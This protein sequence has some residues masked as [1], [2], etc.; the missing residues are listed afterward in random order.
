[1]LKRLLIVILTLITFVHCDLSAQCTPVIGTNPS[2]PKGCELFTVQ[3]FDS[4]DCIIQQRIWSFGDGQ[5]STVE[6]PIHS[7][8]ASVA[9]TD[10]LFNV[11]LAVQDIGGIWTSTSIPVTVYNKP[12][13]SF[14]TDLDTAC[15]INDL[16][17]MVNSSSSGSEFTYN[18]DYGDLTAPGNAFSANHIY[19]NPGDYTITLTVTDTN[20]CAQI[21]QQV[22]TVNEI[23]NPNFSLSDIVGCH[24][25]T[26]EISNTTVPGTFPITYWNWDYSGLSSESTEASSGFTFNDPGIYAITLSA[27]NSA[28]CSNSTANNVFVNETPTA[29]F[30]LPDEACK[31]D[32]VIAV[33]GGTGTFVGSY[34]WSGTNDPDI[35]NGGRGPILMSWDSTGTQTLTLDIEENGCSSTG[36]NTILVHGLPVVELT[37]DAVNDSICEDQE[38]TF[39]ALPDSFVT[40]QFFSLDSVLLQDSP[41]N[42][43]IISTLD[44]NNEISVF[45]VDSNQCESSAISSLAIT[46]LPKPLIGLSSDIDTICKG[47]TV[48]FFATNGFDYYEWFN[49]FA[50]IVDSSSNV[51]S[52]TTL[53]DNDE[54]HAVATQDGCVGNE[55]MRVR[56]TVIDPM[57][58]PQ[59]NCGGSNN[60]SVVFV[61]NELDGATGYQIS[62][63]TQ[64]T[65][66][67]G[68]Y[69]TTF[70][71]DQYIVGGLAPG[72]TVWAKLVANGKF[73][74]GNSYESDAI[75]CIAQPCDTMLFTPSVDTT[76]CFGDSILLSINDIVTPT[77]GFAIS[78]NNMAFGKDSSFYVKPFADSIVNV[79]LIDSFQLGCP[80]F[81]HEFNIGVTYAPS[82]NIITSGDT[83]CQGESVSI[84]S[85]IAGYDN[86]NMLINDTVRLDSNYHVFQ[87]SALFP[88][89]NIIDFEVSD[90]GCFSSDTSYVFIVETPVAVVTTSLDS[91]CL[92]ESYTFLVNDIFDYYEFRYPSNFNG[93]LTYQDS[94]I[95]YLT[96]NSLPEISVIGTDRFGCLSEE[97]SASVVVK[98]L[99]MVSLTVNS[100]SVLCFGDSLEI[101]ASPAGFDFYEFWNNYSIDQVSS[102]VSYKSYEPDSGHFYFTRA[103]N[104]GCVG[105]NSDSVFISV[106]TPLDKPQIN[107]GLTGN[108]SMVFVWDD[109]EFATSYLLRDN[110]SGSSHGPTGGPLGTLYRING[111]SSSD[112]MCV[113]VMAVGPDPCG[114][115][116]WSEPVCCVMPCQPVDFSMNYVDHEVCEGDSVKLQIYNITSPTSNYVISWDGNDF[117]DTLI[118]RFAPSV[119]MEVDVVVQDTTQSHCIP[120]TKTF[121][122][123][124]NPIPNVTLL[125][126][127]LLCA[128]DQAI[129][130]A[131]PTFYN[132]YQFMDGFLPISSGINPTQID[133]VIE[134]GHSYSVIVEENGCYDTSNVI[135]IQVV[136]RIQTPDVF[137]GATTLNTININWDSIPNATGYE[138]SLNGFPWVTP[139]S[140]NLGLTNNI[141]GLSY[142]DSII[143][144]V[145]AITDEPCFYSEESQLITCIADTCGLKNFSKTFDFEPC[146]GEEVTLNMTDIISP[147]DQI[148]I[149]WDQTNYGLD[150]TLTLSIYSDTTITISLIDSTE[151]VCPVLSK[152]INVSIQ[153]TPILTV[154]DNFQNDSLCEGELLELTAD[155][156]GYDA[157]QFFIN[158]VL[159]QDSLFYQFTTDQ[160]SPGRHEV[161]VNS[162]D[163]GCNYQTDSAFFDV[164]AFPDISIF[165]SDD[166]DS[167]CLGDSI[168]FIT[169]DTFDNYEFYINQNLS[170]SGLS[171][172]ISTFNLIDQDSVFVIGVNQNLC[173]QISDTIITTVIDIPTV[174]L[175]SSDL[176]NNFCDGDSILFQ[177][178]PANLDSIVIWVNGDSIASMDSLI[179]LHD[180]LENNDQIQVYGSE[181]GCPNAS[182]TITNFVD[183]RPTAVAVS[184]TNEVCVGEEVALSVSGGD[185]YLWSTGSTQSD[186]NVSPDETTVYT[187]TTSSG[188]CTS[189]NDTLIVLIDSDVPFADAGMEETICRGD[190]IQLFAMGGDNF[191]WL[192]DTVSNDSVFD[193]YVSPFDT[194]TFMVEVF[195][196][197]CRDT[198]EVTITIDRCLEDLPDDIPEIITPNGDGDNDILYIRDIDYFSNCKLTIFNRWS[199]K[200][201]ESV[202]YNNEWYG[203]NKKGNDLPDGTYFYILELGGSFP[204]HTGYVIIH[205]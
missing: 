62:T 59:L 137:C 86:Y 188:A 18:W 1:M 54:I 33:Y 158:D 114:S 81:S 122:I 129:L 144:K 148:G 181:A 82:F 126:D 139:N 201:Y 9:G 96:T 99:P 5:T 57:P 25:M 119:T 44:P 20:G 71:D 147:S 80:A 39:T 159:V 21:A 69:D 107:C 45:A 77:T 113:E 104:D 88:G 78:W 157:Y 23:P 60:S 37:T 140:G 47:E 17:S 32:T 112:T 175:T 50:S 74:C 64:I 192:T 106:S 103:I 58:D 29:E 145:R 15:A 30:V 124:V 38:I 156:I 34:T 61:W 56:S 204:T 7:F 75:F 150:S 142:G 53:E 48:T 108:G 197:Y 16:V 10:T 2:P 128:D 127:T 169:N 161:K 87:S 89:L 166:N 117:G 116:E 120:T 35:Y 55:S 12:E 178:N 93:I 131:T 133:N 153:E 143:A 185:S 167:I 121:S 4:T 85:S 123:K 84:E 202:P 198:S 83:I 40:F 41:S 194:K 65:T 70:F 125:G 68:A 66:G 205:H 76:L 200:V 191:K 187:V 13:A 115:S 186:I 189:W 136:E 172:T 146:Q 97:I 111:L 177:V 8:N 149:S 31:G 155:T 176:D 195:N 22:V 67:F 73:P 26:V 141:D 160:L 3:F 183:F 51:I 98:P 174:T 63:S 184:D 19:N 135:T 14:T 168:S 27:V 170:Q 72:D 173:R 180:S 203:Q 105:P 24:P 196:T 100:D 165:S 193:P 28:G 118:Q 171:D 164:V 42:E 110:G 91:V 90:N 163:N 130:T 132:N 52:I 152:T 162:T 199:N 11:E 36:S 94:T 6:N 151:L 182:N 101:A 134:N 190:S 138:I 49:G 95:N 102:N 154:L 79:A 92:G 179:F 46:V 109:I 43:L